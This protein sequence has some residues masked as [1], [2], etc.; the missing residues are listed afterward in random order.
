MDVDFFGKDVA[1]HISHQFNTAR[2]G[3]FCIMSAE[4]RIVAGDVNVFRILTEVFRGQLGDIGELCLFTACSEPDI[5]VLSGFLEGF[6]REIARND[7]IGFIVLPRRLR[8][9]ASN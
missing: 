2:I 9:T 1:G 6:L 4:N 3:E 7:I 5:A 8:G